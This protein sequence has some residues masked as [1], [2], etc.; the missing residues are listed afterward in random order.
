MR[1]DPVQS[2]NFYDYKNEL[3]PYFVGNFTCKIVLIFVTI[4][5]ES[6]SFAGFAFGFCL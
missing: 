6:G 3:F 5:Y 1:S 2:Q 4:H